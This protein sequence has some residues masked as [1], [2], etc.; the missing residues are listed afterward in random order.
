M[1]RTEWSTECRTLAIS[2]LTL[3]GILLNLHST[4]LL[5]LQNLINPRGKKIK[6]NQSINDLKCK[7]WVEFNSHYEPNHAKTQYFLKVCKLK[8]KQYV[9]G[10][11]CYGYFYFLGWESNPTKS[12]KLICIYFKNQNSSIISRLKYFSWTLVLLFGMG[13]QQSR[14]TV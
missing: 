11:L 6:K 7:T 2:T 10:L 12:T 3:K 5:R 9:Q 8:V 4:F 1:L 14:S 13:V